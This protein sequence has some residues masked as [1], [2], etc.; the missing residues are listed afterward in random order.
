[1]RGPCRMCFGAKEMSVAVLEPGYE[2][3]PLKKY[4]NWPCPCESGLKVKRCCGQ[5]EAI[6]VDVADKIKAYIADKKARAARAK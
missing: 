3:N 5:F 6:P 2:W 1:M 4:R